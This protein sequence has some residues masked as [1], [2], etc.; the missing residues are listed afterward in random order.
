MR[1][2]TTLVNKW[3]NLLLSHH[4]G[5]SIISDQGTRHISLQT[6][7]MV[8]MVLDANTHSCVVLSPWYVLASAE[9]DSE[10]STRNSNATKAIHETLNENEVTGPLTSLVFH[11]STPTIFNNMGVA[12][13]NRCTKINHS[14]RPNVQFVPTFAPAR[15]HVIARFPLK[16]QLQI[17]RDGVPPTEG[18]GAGIEW[19]EEL[20]TS[21][22][23]IDEEYSEGLAGISSLDARR[24]KL[25]EGY[26]FLCDCK[27]CSEELQAQQ[28]R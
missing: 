16:R 9:L 24:K 21:Y 25:R 28:H 23:D 1:V 3:L 11:L 17:G 15:A 5:D 13:Y 18:Q 27:R 14:C 26:G 10:N 2:F 20:R 22:L 7:Q 4:R 8:T 12:L 19:G 6:I